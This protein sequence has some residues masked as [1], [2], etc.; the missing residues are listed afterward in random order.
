M[1]VTDGAPVLVG[2]TG[3]VLTGLYD[4]D[5]TQSLEQCTLTDSAEQPQG[6]TLFV[7][8]DGVTATMEGTLQTD[9][10]IL[11]P[12]VQV[13]ISCQIEDAFPVIDFLKLGSGIDESALLDL[14]SDEHF[15]SGHREREGIDVLGVVG[16]RALEGVATVR[17]RDGDALQVVVA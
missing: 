3:A 12:I 2:D 9:G 15:M 14:R 5:N 4:A 11:S 17:C 8:S 13:N 1:T 16:E 10:P 6:G 7:V